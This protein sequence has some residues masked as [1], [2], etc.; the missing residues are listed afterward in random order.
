MI[1]WKDLDLLKAKMEV[2]IKDNSKIIRKKVM[3]IMNGMM[4]AHFK[5]GGILTN[6][7]A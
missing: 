2:Y 1:K 4:V 6:N 5:D 3:E 7:M